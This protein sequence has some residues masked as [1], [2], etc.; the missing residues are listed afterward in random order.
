MSEAGYKTVFN[1]A[2]NIL[3]Y[4]CL[5]FLQ[6]KIAKMDELLQLKELRIEEL[7]QENQAMKKNAKSAEKPSYK[8]RV[9]W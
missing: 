1:S 6:M 2:K 7:Q 3:S 9:P 8:G 5:Q 4:V